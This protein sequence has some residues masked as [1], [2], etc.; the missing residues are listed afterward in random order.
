MRAAARPP[1]GDGDLVFRLGLLAVF[2]VGL[3]VTAR[4]AFLNS[5]PFA[6]TFTYLEPWRNLFEGRGLV[7][8]YNVVYGWSG[9]LSRPALAYYNP[10]YG[11]WIALP[12]QLFEN[13]AWV[14]VFSNALPC[15][16]NAVALGLLTRR[17]FGP[18]VALLSALGYVLLPTTWLGM[19]LICA[20]HATVGVL[21]L[22]LLLIEY[23]VRANERAWVWVGVV[24]G[25]G[26]LV[27]VSVL[28]VVPLL[29]VAAPLMQEGTLRIRILGSVRPLLRVA[30][31]FAAIALPY[32]VV[33]QVV[34]GEL[35]PVYPN[36]ARNWALADAYGGSYLPESPAVRPDAEAVPG[37]AELL[38]ITLEN[39]WAMLWAGVKEVG[40][41]AFFVPAAFVRGRARGLALLLVVT[42]LTMAIGH[43]ASFNFLRLASSDSPRR[44]ALY[45]AVFWYPVAVCGL[46]VCTAWIARASRRQSV[47]LLVAWLVLS[48]P[49]VSPLRERYEKAAAVTV[50]KML[51]WQ[52]SME[53]IGALVGPDELVAVGLGGP[54]L[55]LDRPVVSLPAGKLATPTALA[56]FVR[57]FR[58]TMV[59]PTNPV[60]GRAIIEL[61]YRARAAPGGRV[62]LLRAGL[63]GP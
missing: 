16:M 2:A 27:K 48:L 52:R 20:E 51:A 32:A 17:A 11:L 46:A 50:P 7:T 41:L 43:A 25:V 39:G 55:F 34:V 60:V 18:A 28:L 35:Y 4:Y 9:E 3:V 59:V 37:F 58:P 29:V 42:G 26:F 40:F 63:A 49:L 13:P 57:V 12:F 30:A 8:R 38:V 21:L 5:V 36:M 44:Y 1:K 15:S 56:Q 31:G 23:R 61:G 53:P 33:C 6:D 62:V 47:G 10:L 45:S 14:G 54:S 19:T 22:L 24:L